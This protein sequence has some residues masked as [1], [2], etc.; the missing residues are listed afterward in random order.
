MWQTES[1]KEEIS[2]MRTGCKSKSND[3]KA[4]QIGS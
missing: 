2:E 4:D 3:K 1:R